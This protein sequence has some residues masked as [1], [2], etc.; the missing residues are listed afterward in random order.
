M[1]RRFLFID[2]TIVTNIPE[3]ILKAG[4]L[5]EYLLDCDQ[6]LYEE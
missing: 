4:K 1:S 3:M 2:Y 6:K 5:L